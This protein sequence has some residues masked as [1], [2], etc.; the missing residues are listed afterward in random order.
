MDYLDFS[1]EEFQKIFRQNPA[2]NFKMKVK[3]KNVVETDEISGEVIRPVAMREFVAK[4]L[5]EQ[6]KSFLKV[7]VRASGT[8]DC[9][10][11]YVESE[12]AKLMRD[13][14]LKMQKFINSQKI[15]N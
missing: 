11:V 3:N 10:R 8:E 15:F 7:Y 14:K 1:F 6:G 5:E 12:N 9:L 4:L 13:V 2:T